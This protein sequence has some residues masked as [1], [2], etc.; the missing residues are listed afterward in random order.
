MGTSALA[1]VLDRSPAEVESTLIRLG[2]MEKVEKVREYHVS[3]WKPSGDW[4]GENAEGN[5]ECLEK[6]A[7]YAAISPGVTLPELIMVLDRAKLP[8]RRRIVLLLTALREA[9]EYGEFSLLAHFV[10]GIMSLDRDSLGESEIHEV[11]RVFEPRRLRWFSTLA[12]EDFVLDCLPLLRDPSVRALALTRLGELELLRNK[13]DAAEEHL[14]E[15]LRLSLE[16]DCICNIPIILESIGEIPRD[17]EAMKRMS[18]E[19]EEVLKLLN[20]MDDSELKARITASAAVAQSGLRMSALA[21]RTALQA[22]NHIASLPLETQ[23]VLEWC[24]AR[25]YIA[26]GRGRMV[27]PMLQRSL[28]LAESVNDQLAVMEILNTIVKEMKERSGFTLRS[29][30]AILESVAAKAYQSGN[31]SNRIHALDYLVDMYTRTIQL[32]LTLDAAREMRGIAE[33]PIM[34]RG[35]PLW[36][37]CLAYTGFLT[38]D[39]EAASAGDALL[40]GTSAYLEAMTEN[41]DPRLE[42]RM[43]AEGQMAAHG[44]ERIIYVLILAMEAFARGFRAA[45]SELASSLDASLDASVENQFVSWKLCISAL[46][47]SRDIYADDFLQSAQVM[48][49]QLD[50]LLLV[51]LILRCRLQLEVERNGDHG[52]EILF[53]ASELDLFIRDQFS[54]ERADRFMDECGGRRRLDRIREITGKDT[55]DLATLR[56]AMES[57]GSDDAERIFEIRDISARISGRSEISAS[58]EILGRLMDAQ[59]VMALRV[60]MGEIQIIE[61]YGIGKWRMPSAELQELVLDCPR[62]RLVMDNFGT[63]PFGSRRSTL[64]PL[65]SSVQ[66][67]QMRTLLPEQSPVNNFLLLERDS[68]FPERTGIP[69]FLISSLCGQVSAALMLRSRESMAYLDR[70]TGAMIGY[71]WMN[72][73]EETIRE[74]VDRQ[75]TS[76]LLAD[77]DSLQEINRHFGFRAGDSILKR[78]VALFTRLLRPNDLV[79]RI[80]GDLF[81]IMLPQTGGENARTVAERICGAVAGT[82]L[83]PDRVPLTVSIG[84]ACAESSAE[85]P[86]MVLNR[87]A[88]AMREAKQRG[89]NRVQAWNS[90][91]QFRDQGDLRIFYTG[92]P[93]WD[94][95]V[96]SCVMELLSNDGPSLESV[97]RKLRDALRSELVYLEDGTGGSA[98]AGSRFLRSMA[99]EIGSGRRGSVTMHQSLLGKYDALSTGLSGGGRL[100]C[101]W[102]TSGG[103]SLSL[104]NIFMALASLTDSLLVRMG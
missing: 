98:F 62:E 30:I 69:H 49:R 96:S 29:L 48:A 87:A 18:D 46:L 47:S 53:L 37:W 101:A 99:D 92:D 27:I 11:L 33:S 9:R 15:A 75:F 84:T 38:G 6:L 42:A 24:R 52:R 23:L 16:N 80:R 26:S 25:V 89:G 74:Q 43:I 5:S 73:L 22:M 64:I 100:I 40:P 61:G 45:A 93:G 35:Q 51:W 70:L 76:V 82:D 60:T 104:K 72:R 86:D 20:D 103:I 54:G 79:G 41:R 58:L 65:G 78:L 21:E 88:D 90:R 71:S 1:Y 2:R 67:T 36:Q 63:N 10:S 83:R 32:N 13:P 28:M 81:G 68:P 59:R 55:G 56:D 4:S 77:V 66:S 19:V 3:V 12:A 7:E 50:R 97:V 57:S 95:T 31:M 14:S 39:M 85:P 102:D 8:F 94:H 44:F 34:L 91:M 17:F